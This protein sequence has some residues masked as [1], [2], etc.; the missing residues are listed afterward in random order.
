MKCLLGGHAEACTTSGVVGCVG[1]SVRSS[2]DCF[3]PRFPGTCSGTRKSSGAWCTRS[4]ATSATSL[5][6]WFLSQSLIRAGWGKGEKV[7]KNGEYRARSRVLSHVYRNSQEFRHLE[8]PKCC[9]F[10]YISP[11]VV[12]EPEPYSSWLGKRRESEEKW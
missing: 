10:G 7:K 12:S 3:S 4:V 8:R 1:K 6:W 5:P 2:T 11:V 9:H